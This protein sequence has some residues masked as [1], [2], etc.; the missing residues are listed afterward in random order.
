MSKAKSRSDIASE[1]VN[2]I[3]VLSDFE[4]KPYLNSFWNDM[5]LLVFSIV[6]DGSNFAIFSLIFLLTENFTRYLVFLFLLYLFSFREISLFVTIFRTLWSDAGDLPCVGYPSFWLAS[7]ASSGE[8][9]P[10]LRKGQEEDQRRWT[11]PFI[12]IGT[13]TNPYKNKKK[14]KGE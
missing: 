8:N 11:E 14:K 4:V 1:L 2:I 5:L 9:Q 7:G 12:T 10:F 6:P 3:P 13:L